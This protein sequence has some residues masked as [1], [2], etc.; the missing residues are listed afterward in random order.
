MFYSDETMHKIMEDD[1]EYNP[2][3]RLPRILISDISQKIISFLL[4]KLIDFQDN[5]IKLKINLDE[6]NEKEDKKTKDSNY[7]N[8]KNTESENNYNV[9]TENKALTLFLKNNR[10][11]NFCSGNVNNSSGRLFKKR[12][13]KN[14]KTSKNTEGN[15]NKETN[16]N[17]IKN[18][19]EKEANEKKYSENNS[20][21][22]KK[23][24]D[25]EKVSSKDEIIEKIKKSFKWRR[26]I[27]YIIIIILGLFSWYYASCFCAIYNKTQKHLYLDFLFSIPMSFGSCF[28]SCFFILLIKL[29]IKTGEY[30]CIKKWVGKIFGYEI[31]SLIIEIIIELFIVN[32]LT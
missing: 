29:L 17:E 3:Y 13:I 5:F 26:I 30:S 1:G 19:N 27:F 7:D 4:S 16:E 20:K 15:E 22:D 31:I 11:N 2:L 21:N 24:K 8:K 23:I 28:I 18:E 6:A 10:M 32:I 14:Y 9:N 12:S 25:S